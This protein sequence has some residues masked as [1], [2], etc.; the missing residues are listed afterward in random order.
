MQAE[1]EAERS[2]GTSDAADEVRLAVLEDNTRMINR[3]F[4]TV[5]AELEVA[6]S[7]AAN[8]AANEVRLAVLED[9]KRVLEA[10]VAALEHQVH[11]KAPFLFGLRAEG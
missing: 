2:V 1:L 6:R 11:A 3:V 8:D 7:T 4:T 5:Q 9:D 10:R